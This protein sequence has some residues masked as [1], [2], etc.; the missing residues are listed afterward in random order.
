VVSV[1]STA[2]SGPLPAEHSFVNADAENVTITAI[3]KAEDSNA[4]LVRFYEWAGKPTTVT[5]SVPPGAKAAYI[6]DL[7]ER[8]QGGP[9]SLSGTSV[10]VPV[11]P[12]EIQT[13]R[14]DY[15]VETPWKAVCASDCNSSVAH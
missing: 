13:V 7:L 2:H 1:Q 6:T 10:I 15:T 3:K 9:L 11:K 14:I 4:L 5:L 8:T 12:Y